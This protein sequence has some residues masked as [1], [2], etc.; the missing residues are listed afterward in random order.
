[1]IKKDVIARICIL[2]L[3]CIV[4]NGCA[5]S[6]L[7]G[8]IQAP[9][10]KWKL[11]FAET[12]LPWCLLSGGSHVQGETDFFSSGGVIDFVEYRINPGQISSTDDVILTNTVGAVQKSA[13]DTGRRLMVNRTIGGNLIVFEHVKEDPDKPTEYF[14]IFRSKDIFVTID[15]E[16]AP[17]SHLPA[18]FDKDAAEHDCQTIANSFQFLNIQ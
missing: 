6:V 1:M 16:I 8:E 7:R 10:G 5:K 18:R 15:C 4:G 17:P 11:S 2:V 3:T 12:A 9:S 13:R 14:G